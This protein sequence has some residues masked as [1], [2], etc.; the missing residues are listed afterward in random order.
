[1]REDSRRT[2]AARLFAAGETQAVVARRLGIARSTS[3]AWHRLWRDGKLAETRRAGR[4][5]RLD[6]VTLQ[7]L[8]DALLD[9]PREHGLPLDDWSLQAIAVLIERRTGV[10][11]HPRHVTR[12]VRR[13]G[14]LVPPF[15]RTAAAASLARRVLDPSGTPVNLLFRPGRAPQR[16]GGENGSRGGGSK[17]GTT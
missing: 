14:W 3:S 10:R 1:M 8:G 13:M 12:L 5:P 17:S 4:P 6:G 15:E 2:E 11:Y 16:G 7:A 9:P